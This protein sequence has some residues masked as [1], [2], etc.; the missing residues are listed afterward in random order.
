MVRVGTILLVAAALSGCASN[1][2]LIA[3]PDVEQEIVYSG[4]IGYVLP[5][6]PNIVGIGPS[7][8]FTTASRVAFEILVENKSEAPFDVSPVA[9]MARTGEKNEALATV[10]IEEI[11]AEIMSAVSS[12]KFI[13]GLSA[14][15][16]AL[17]T[18]GAAITAN[19]RAAQSGYRSVADQVEINRQQQNAATANQSAPLAVGAAQNEADAKLGQL[20]RRQTVFPGDLARG[21]VIKKAPKLRNGAPQNIEIVINI[22]G[23]DYRAVMKYGPW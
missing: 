12:A 17:Q 3:A 16:G 2:K 13:A 11:E 5:M 18:A 23:D 20:L 21:V 4:G 10:P 15:S 8:E 9:V 6:G 7:P 22:G 1:M 19:E 14:V